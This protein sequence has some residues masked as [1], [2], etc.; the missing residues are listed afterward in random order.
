MELTL[1][2]PI[3]FFPDAG[4]PEVEAGKEAIRLTI[5]RVAFAQ[6]QVEIDLAALFYLP[7]AVADRY[8]HV[9]EALVLVV[10]DLEQADAGAI[11]MVNT[12]IEYP[13]GS[14][15]GPNQIEEPALPMPG[16]GSLVSEGFRG[17]WLNV[18]VGFPCA[19][20]IPRYRPSAWVYLVL[21]NYV[22]NV[23][24]LDLVSKTAVSF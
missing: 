2:S 9:E 7:I 23:V 18:T 21:E 19:S 20:P 17:S 6:G 8:H 12:F 15:D 1:K 24:G 3:G 4:S 13:A 22:S 11:L 10:N 16:R 5:S 14:R